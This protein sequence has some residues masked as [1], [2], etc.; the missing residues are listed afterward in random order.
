MQF[1][2]QA[3]ET[4]SSRYNRHVLTQHGSY[5]IPVI[6][7]LLV[8]VDDQENTERF[9]ISTVHELKQVNPHDAT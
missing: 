2:V 4:H 7:Q 6:M 5:T 1:K 3:I 8:D 9:A